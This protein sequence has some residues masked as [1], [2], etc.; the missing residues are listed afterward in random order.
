MALYFRGIPMPSFLNRDPQPTTR[1]LSPIDVDGRPAAVTLRISERA[2]K[3]RITV[4]GEG[5]ELVVPKRARLRDAHAFLADS[6][7]WI[8]DRVRAARAALADHP[9]SAGLADGGKIL[10]RSQ[11]V[12]LEIEVRRSRTASIE[13]GERLRILLPI[14]LAGPRREAAIE[15]VLVRWLRAEARSDAAA[16]V[17]RHGPP[18]GLVPKALRIKEQSRLWG[19]CSTRGGINLNWRLIFAPPDVFE[20][21]VVHELCHLE[22]PHHQPPFWR[23]V[24][25][26]MPDYGRR[27]RWLK[28]NGHL[29]TLRPGGSI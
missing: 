4:R 29:L 26:L 13:A 22:H 25:E 9:G 24:A 1:S 3:I 15:Q 2:Q 6:E 17:A 8:R 19:S 16:Y 18:N 7:P 27:R 10:L 21:V 23:R 28:E 5:V 14:F 11:A 12:E 20:Y